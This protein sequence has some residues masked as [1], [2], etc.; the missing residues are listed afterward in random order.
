MLEP[1]SSLQ[2][3]CGCVSSWPCT[4]RDNTHA[5][6]KSCTWTPGGSLRGPGA[7]TRPEVLALSGS[8]P[9]CRSWVPCS[10]DSHTLSSFISHTSAMIASR[11]MTAPLRHLS[12]AERRQKR[13]AD[14]FATL[15]ADISECE[16]LEIIDTDQPRQ[17]ACA[18]LTLCRF[19]G[20]HFLTSQSSSC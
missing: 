15:T 1:T 19:Y 16:P 8:S 10:R 4:V 9:Y 5:K 6:V 20:L 13:T 14:L 12:I 17:P 7:R 18:R 11:S 2:P 3:Q